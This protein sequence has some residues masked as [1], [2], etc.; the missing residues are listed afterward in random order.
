MAEPTIGGRTAEQ[1]M[2]EVVQ[3]AYA[4]TI[5]IATV[6]GLPVSH[7]ERAALRAG[8]SA[9][10][11]TLITLLTESGALRMDGEP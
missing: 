8:A 10:A 6:A 9:G 2:A 11:M 1:L 3:K 4:N 5:A 7:A